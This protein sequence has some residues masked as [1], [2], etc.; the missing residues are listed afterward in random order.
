MTDPAIQDGHRNTLY[1]LAAVSMVVM[2]L[3]VAVQPLFLRN[4]LGISFE[5]AGMINANLQ[6][7]TEVL[8]LAVIF[9]LGYLSDRFGRVPIVTAGFL[10]AAAGALMAPLSVQLGV[11]LGIGG[12]AAYYLA[13]IV[14]SLGTGAVWPQ[15]S[16]L[17]GDFTRF[18]DRPRLIA[19]TAF[20]M[21]FGG[22]LVY[23]VL[24]Q[25]PKHVGILSVML[26]TVGVALIG[27]WL[28]N[29][30]LI[31]V[32]PRLKEGTIPWRRV[33][34]LIVGDERLRLTF[35]SAFFFR[36]DMVFIGLF[37]MMWFIY[38][39]DLVGI[40]QEEAAAHA[41]MLIGLAGVVVMATLPLWGRITERVG[42]VPAIALGTA[43]SGIG[44]A[45]MGFIVNPFDWFIVFP[46]IL[47]A[48]G[49]AG[50]L[51]APQVLTIDLTP[52]EIRGSVLGAFNVVGGI[53][54]IFFV[55]TGG[56]L[57]DAVGPHAPFVFLGIGNIVLMCYAFW[58]MRG[59]LRKSFATEAKESEN[60]EI[61]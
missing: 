32:A 35:V 24:M 34:D 14:M 50:C 57:F 18:A 43:L 42:R 26:I 41:G 2:T 12:L 40:E 9:Y 51:V 10:V 3:A 54:I 25:I 13:R 58:V 21:A 44:F 20:M 8:D 56:A 30:R 5:Y 33:R 23:A 46:I 53:G 31:D 1:L 4:V 11:L 29:A 38:F 55:Q 28:A 48:I 49:Q 52:K 19:N 45:V 22:T 37:V 61:V 59:D 47:V 16:T 17:A 39:A 27:A 36:S 6:V 15:L 7:V 60:A